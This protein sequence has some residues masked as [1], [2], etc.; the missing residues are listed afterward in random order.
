MRIEDRKL[1]AWV[2]EDDAEMRR[3]IVKVLYRLGFRVDEFSDGKQLVE[4]IEMLDETDSVIES[5]AIVIVDHIMPEVHG[6]DAV[7]QLKNLH[8]EIPFIVIT[9]FGD[10]EL[11][12][13]AESLGAVAVL[14]KPFDL[15]RFRDLTLRFRV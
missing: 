15:D 2:A 12:K 7:S 4:R 8:N 11:H 10:V 3:M 1:L 5:P 6:L 9:A 14:D 13:R